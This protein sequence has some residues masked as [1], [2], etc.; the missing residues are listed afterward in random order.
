MPPRS[1]VASIHA[2]S[3]SGR[4]ATP[5]RAQVE[6]AGDG[7]S[8][9]KGGY[10]LQPGEDGN[11]SGSVLESLVEEVPMALKHRCAIAYRDQVVSP[12]P[13]KTECF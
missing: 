11:C 8:A 7:T 3:S 5:Y 12:E 9:R 1:P 13:S 2:C 6:V 4:S 10:S